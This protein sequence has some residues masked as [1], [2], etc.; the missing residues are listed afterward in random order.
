MKEKVKIKQLLKRLFITA[1]IIMIYV[2]GTHL[3]LPF[4][5][6]TKGY[7]DLIENT[8]ISIMG[9]MSGA[10]FLRLS[11]FSIGLNPM[12][13]AMMVIQ[14]L[15]MTKA[16]GF[17]ALPTQQVEIIQQIL[18]FG[19][20]ILQSTFFTLGLHL[21]KGI[22]EELIVILLL[23]TGSMLVN[24]MSVMNI[25]FGI[26]GTMP[27]ILI[28]ILTGSMPSMT[29]AIQNLEKMPDFTFYLVILLIVTLLLV[30][31][32]NAF[33]HAYY[34]LKTINTSLDSS[35]KPIIIPLGLNMGAMMTYMMGMAILSLPTL[36][37][38]YF[39]YNSLMNNIIF[40]AVVST[41]LAFGLFYFFTFMQFN[42]K[43]QA[44]ALRNNGSYI[45]GIRPN[46]PTQKYI[47]KLLWIVT[48]PGA[49]LTAFQLTLGLMGM[50]LLGD[51]AG[52]AILPMNA[53]MVTMFMN[54][55]KDQITILLF[56]H[57]YNKLQ[58]EV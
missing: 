34:P 58:K 36:L 38:S 50:Q 17:D 42:P 8:P 9:M 54:N 13:I 10:D 44:K 29:K 20:A 43:E 48:F 27:I 30:I 24:W 56:P 41:L 14:L 2:L 5:E 6:V 52:F 25:R 49:C 1:L 16:F 35:A 22:P 15:V 11:V 53:V 7:T 21:T 37:A 31:F 28:N 18:V 4:A 45:L 19:F 32:W 57:K 23:V 26:G 47:R 3:P 33:S 51:Y 12:M 40:Q 55:A 39:S 46:L